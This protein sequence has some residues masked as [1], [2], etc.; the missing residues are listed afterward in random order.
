M[1]QIEQLQ[2]L[3]SH[4]NGFISFFK[5]KLKDYGASRVKEFQLEN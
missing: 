2:S 5:S 1:N 3:L 4:V